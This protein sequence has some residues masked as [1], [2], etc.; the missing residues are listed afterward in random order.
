MQPC[1]ELAG[2][3]VRKDRDRFA[4]AVIGVVCDGLIF[5]EVTKQF[6]SIFMLQAA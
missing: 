2:G 1:L 6:I 5:D 4:I 3:P